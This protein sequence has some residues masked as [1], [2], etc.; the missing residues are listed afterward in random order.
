MNNQNQSLEKN[1]IDRAMS[2]KNNIL[3]QA[4]GNPEWIKGCSESEILLLENK[5][6]VIL[7]LSYK[8]FLRNFGHGLG[9]GI[10]KEIDILYDKIFNLTNVIRNEVLVDEGDPVLPNK[11]FV[12]AGR[13]NEQFMFFN[14]D[15]LEEEPSIFYYMIDDEKFR[16][17]G[18]SIFDILESEIEESLSIKHYRE[19]NKK[20]E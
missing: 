8:V 14:A 17:I 1:L 10:M 16:K 11:A 18:D 15:G 4:L 2:L 6:D 20:A 5:Y 12:F 19:Q 3:H 13:Y 7:P 9:G